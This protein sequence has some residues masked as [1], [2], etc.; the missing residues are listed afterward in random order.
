MTIL[1]YII[2]GAALVAIC[3]LCVQ[4]ALLEK[5]P[6]EDEGDDAADDA[7]IER[8]KAASKPAPLSDMDAVNEA[9]MQRP[10]KRAGSAWLGD[11]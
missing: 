10:H 7:A 1:S 6:Y 2:G 5:P 8:I 9:Y 3:W 4:A 11:A